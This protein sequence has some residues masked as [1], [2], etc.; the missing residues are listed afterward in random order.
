M[1]ELAQ[2]RSRIEQLE[3]AESERQRAQEVLLARVQQQAVVAD[4]G[5]CA[6]TEPDLDT[7]FQQAVEIV[8]S[9]LDVDYAKVLQLLPDGAALRLVAGVGWYPGLVGTATVGTGMDSQAGYTLSSSE[10]VIV[11]DLRTE[12]RFRGPA[13][14][15]DHGVISG[16]SVVIH[17]QGQPFGVLG[18]H[19]RE[20]RTFTVDDAAFL[21]AVANVLA[22]TVQREHA[23][24]E[25]R[26]LTQREA[27]ARQEAERAARQLRELRAVSDPRLVDQA[28]DDLLHPMLERLASLLQVDTVAIL[29]PDDE[30]CLVVRAATGLEEEKANTVRIPVGMG[31]AGRIAASD[32]PLVL[33]DL[34]KE[35]V[36]NQVLRSAGVR[37]LVGVPLRVGERRGVIHAGSL[38]P[39]HFGDDD[40]HLLQRVADLVGAALDQV[41]TVVANRKTRTDADASTLLETARDEDATLRSVARLAVPDLADFCIVHAVG[42]DRRIRP[43]AIAHARDSQEPILLRATDGFDIALRCTTGPLEEVIRTSQVVLVS[44]VDESFLRGLVGDG[45]RLAYLQGLDPRSAMLVPLIA[46][47]RTVGAMTCIATDGN[48]GYGAVDIAL[49]EG[50][51]RHAALA[52]DNARLFREVRAA[53][54]RYRNLFEQVGDAMLLIG[55]DG[56]YL[57][58]NPAASEILGY[59][60]QEFRRMRL[61]ALVQAEEGW[62]TDQFQQ[63]VRDGFWQGEMELRRKDGSLVPVEGQAQRIVLPEGEAY[64]CLWRDVSRR[65][66]V[67]ELQRD[68]LESVS[69]DLQTPLTA[70]S[71]AITLLG[72]SAA[73]RLRPEERELLANATRNAERL[74]NL[75]ADL[76]AYNELRSG[77][78]SLDRE[79]VD[80]GELVEDIV[81]ATAPLMNGKNQTVSVTLDDGLCVEGDR[82]RIEQVL[83]NIVM[84]AHHHTPEGTTITVIGER[85]DGT[86]MITISDDGPGIAPAELGAIFQRF[87]RLSASDGGAGLG[88]AIARRLVE[89]HGGRIWAESGP[90]KGASFHIELPHVDGENRL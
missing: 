72:V 35:N 78:M 45:E 1:E 33:D 82:R 65:R 71:A 76:L 25:R 6:L 80:V 70:L 14:L 29:L 62:A 77:A 34:S 81:F 30:D 48:R 22:A 88:L 18:A 89:L 41:R 32:A 53:E 68:F 43:A 51:A 52:I 9:T 69:H 63:L 15:Q 17:G 84:N 36:V 79:P 40:V 49:A 5:I 58:A 24:T 42:Y 46:R 61:G 4:L 87:H 47:G 66:A 54:A 75:I 44:D 86:A 10:P 83:T 67:E 11:E 37:S 2:M 60:R 19:S 59:S 56:R 16:L 50:L 64:I 23:E 31:V 13:L 20:K 7:L 74:R 55:P 39:R 3:Q 85:Q 27:R 8:R 38:A 73:G 21:Q 90:G 28:V 57:D 26:R 12:P